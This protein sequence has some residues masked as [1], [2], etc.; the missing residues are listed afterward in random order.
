VILLEPA[1]CNQV[2]SCRVRQRPWAPGSWLARS[3]NM[4]GGRF[5]AQQKYREPR[6][7]LSPAKP[8]KAGLHVAQ[9]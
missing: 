1:V 2:V 4:N 9:T 5:F 6:C 8:R 3:A 7:E